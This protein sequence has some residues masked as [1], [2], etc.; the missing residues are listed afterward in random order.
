MR[1]LRIVTTSWD[2]GDRAD[3]RV[4]ELL[5][6]RDIPGSFY[7]PVIPYRSDVLSHSELRSL[8]SEGFEIG[9]HGYSHR[10]LWRLSA[11]DLA[12]EIGPCKP[13]LEDILGKEVQMFCYPQGRHDANVIRALKEAGYSGAR[14]IR[15]LST[16]LDFRPFEMPTSVQIFPHP[17]SNYIKNVARAQKMEGLQACLANFTRLGNWLDL[18]KRLFDS[19]LQNGG[20]WHM[21]GHSWE[22][23]ALDLW[24]D[25]ERILDYVH[26]REGV[27]YVTNGEALQLL[28]ASRRTVHKTE[29]VKPILLNN[30][31]SN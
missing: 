23:D 26:N 20:I 27:T 4:A 22:I 19:V 31:D 6:Q 16:R 10:L 9:A 29:N 14:T 11:A 28:C 30:D 2:D 17:I 7:V 13:A 15:M 3:L 1:H 12:R 5:R 24:K 8:S 25:L 21:Y 18:G